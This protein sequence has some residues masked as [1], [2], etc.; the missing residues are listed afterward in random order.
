MSK[1]LLT[2]AGVENVAPPKSGRVDYWD[3]ILPGF[4]LRVTSNGVKTYA[5]KGRVHGK[6]VK[7]TIGRAEIIRLPDAREAGRSLLLQMSL[8]KNPNER[9]RV[10]HDPDSLMNAVIDEYLDIGTSNAK[11]TT[12]KMI[13][14][15]FRR[16]VRPA[17]RKR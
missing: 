11:G 9:H 4:H 13:K 1:K 6:Q 16:H 17:D 2:V 12:R 10:R 8:G 14:G 3:T 5:V 7:C 15:T